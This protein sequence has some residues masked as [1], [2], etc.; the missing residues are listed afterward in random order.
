[1]SL[2]PL[3][4]TPAASPALPRAT[5]SIAAEASVDWHQRR[6][7]RLQLI[8][9][10]LALLAS[11]WFAKLALDLEIISVIGLFIWIVI[12][13]IAW[14]PYVGLCVAYGLVMLFEDGGPDPLMLP[15]YYL[16][17][18]LGASI[19]IGLG[20]SPI[21]LL[22]ILT[23]STWFLKGIA[24][25]QIDWRGGTLGVPV[26]LFL[27]ALIA[28]V[29]R[30]LVGG[31]DVNTALWESRFLFYAVMCYFV[32]ANTVRTRRQ[33]T[34]LVM[35]TVLGTGIFA[36]EGAYRRVA[37]IDT[38]KLGVIPEF[39]YAH[40]DVIFLG[41]LPLIVLAM[42]AFGARAWQR[43]LGLALVPVSLFTLLATERRAGFIALI[44]A[45]IAFGLIF[46]IAHRKAFFLITV[47]MLIGLA[48][49]LP[50]FWNNTSMLGQPARA[51]RSL[52][53]PDA[54]DAASNLYR[55]LELINVRST[56]HSNPI[57][58]VGFGRPFDF[59]VPLPDLSWWAFWHYEPHHNI[60]WVWLKLGA[61]GFIIFWVLMTTATA[62]AA[63]A[64]RTLRSSEQ[65]IFALLA[66]CA[67]IMTVSFCYVDL[68]LVSGRV[69]IFLGA[70]L[71]A[72]SVLNELRD[73]DPD[74]IT[75]T[76]R[77]RLRNQSEL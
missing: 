48:V 46:V 70:A 7:R 19:R 42:W 53:Q 38:G 75:S 27:L 66:L 34:Q 64:V 6:Q 61:P 43:W 30:G 13:A 76:K 41:S 29:I 32:A 77:L 9:S 44:I 47:P 1:M 68:G 71:G 49:Y 50:L 40:A 36:I 37:L 45:F 20:L 12:V 54:R 74:P 11:V 10:V 18:G 60:L 8:L 4:L 52:S 58:G 56:I 5:L 23:F 73:P 25:R 3:R 59:T 31:G 14:R 16:H 51:V 22:L 15:G 21:E 63:Y 35:L 24:R 57:L 39:A 65:R 55:D 17:S 62:R 67:I 28:G 33:L 69:T 26:L 2:G 72:L